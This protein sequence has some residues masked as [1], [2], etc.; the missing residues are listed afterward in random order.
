[1]QNLWKI[2]LLICNNA[3]Y[4]SIQLVF[5]LIEDEI[6][7]VGLGTSLDIATYAWS[8]FFWVSIGE[9][10]PVTKTQLPH[11]DNTMPWKQYSGEDYKRHV[12]FCGTEVIRTE[13]TAQ[14]PARAV[15]LKTG[16]SGFSV[17]PEYLNEKWSWVLKTHILLDITDKY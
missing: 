17:L 8:L 14:G 16:R 6:S 3:V 15:V 9:C 5:K 7:L 10:I 13:S 11:M 1:M 12:L 2:K 4:L